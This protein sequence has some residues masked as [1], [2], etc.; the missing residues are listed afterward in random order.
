MVVVALVLVVFCEDTHTTIDYIYI[1][2]YIEIQ[3]RSISNSKTLFRMEFLRTPS[4]L[5]LAPELL[6]LIPFVLEIVPE[7]R[8]LGFLLV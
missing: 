6:V 5:Q 2:I 1:Y 8:N 3:N 7:I 4:S